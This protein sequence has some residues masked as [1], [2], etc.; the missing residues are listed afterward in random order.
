MLPGF[1]GAEKVE[2]YKKSGHPD[3]NQ[4]LQ[5]ALYA[6]CESGIQ[7]GWKVDKNIKN[8]YLLPFTLPYPT[9]FLIGFNI[10]Y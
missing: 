6:E 8:P 10:I 1:Q 2:I 3:L 9:L 4:E 7:N 5:V